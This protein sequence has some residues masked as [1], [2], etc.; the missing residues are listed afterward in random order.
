[1]RQFIII[2]AGANPASARW[3]VTDGRAVFGVYLSE[4]G[5]MLAA[6]D[7]AWEMGESVLT[8]GQRGVAL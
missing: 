2:K 3:S 6:I 4:W 7:A 5:A 1:M 8:R